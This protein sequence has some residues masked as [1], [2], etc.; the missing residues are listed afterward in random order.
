MRWKKPTKDGELASSFGQLYYI[1]MENS[2]VNNVNSSWKKSISLKQQPLESS[3]IN[4]YFPVYDNRRHLYKTSYFPWCIFVSFYKERKKKN[5]LIRY[6]LKFIHST[7]RWTKEQKTFLYFPWKMG[8][9]WW[10][11]QSLQKKKKKK[12]KNLGVI[13]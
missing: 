11:N 1:P 12:L 3:G 5:T 10:V 2:K 8:V 9:Y 13:F 6:P 4:I 7:C